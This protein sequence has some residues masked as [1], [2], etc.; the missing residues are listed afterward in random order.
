MFVPTWADPWVLGRL[1]E[2]GASI[3]VCPRAVGD[4]PGDPC[5]HRFRVAVDDGAVPFVVQGPENALSLDTGRTIGW[6]VI[7]GLGHFLDRTFVQV[8]GGA[9]AAC[10]GLAATDA[11]IHPRLHAVQAEGCAPL[12][13]AWAE[14]QRVGL[15]RAPKAWAECMWPW[16]DEPRSIADGILDDETYDW[17]GVVQAMAAGD[18]SPVVVTEAEIA[19]AHDLARRSTGLPVSPTGSAG[20]AGLLALRPS[21]DDGERIAI[22]FTGR[23]HGI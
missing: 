17:V 8:G 13:R 3:E 21:I 19:E 18:G 4:P 14:A 11:G 23:S 10:M 9:L 20:L 15:A 16:E 1:A 22:L 6:E 12:A 7:E 5:V 2:L